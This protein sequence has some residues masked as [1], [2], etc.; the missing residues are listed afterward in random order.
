[1]CPKYGIFSEVSGIRLSHRP[2]QNIADGQWHHLAEVATTRNGTYTR[3]LYLDGKEVAKLDAA[4]ATPWWSLGD[5][6]IVKSKFIAS[7]GRVGKE[8]WKGQLDDFAVFDYA[9]TPDDVAYLYN[10]P[11]DADR[12][13]LKLVPVTKVEAGRNHTIQLPGSYKVQL[14][15]STPTIEGLKPRWRMVSGNGQVS[16]SDPDGASTVAM[17]EPV[18]DDKDG[19]YTKFV[20]R[21]SLVDHQGRELAGDN[22]TVL[23]HPA[24]APEI[25][26]LTE[27]PPP[28]EHPR[29][30]F[31]KADL[32][33]LRRRAEASP[34]A[35]RAVEMMR[36]RSKGLD[37]PDSV[38][39]AILADRD[40]SI[41][42]V[43]G[44]KGH[45]FFTP[46]MEAAY[47]NWLGEAG[48]TNTE[49]MQELARVF[50][51][52]CQES[53]TWYRPNYY[54]VLCHDV[55]W[56]VG[57]AYDL[58]HDYMDEAGRAE[59]RHLIS[60]MTSHR[61]SKGPYEPPQ[62]NATNHRG[63][64][65]H[66]FA[67]TLA[68]EG[69]EGFDEG[70]IDCIEKKD[71]IW[72]T[73]Y[74]IFESGLP[75]EGYAY[76][77]HGMSWMS[78]TILANTRRKN[79]ENLAET[80]RFYRAVSETP[81]RLLDKDGIRSHHDVVE[82]TETG[83]GLVPNPPNQ[84]M[85]A[86]YLWP[87]DRTIDYVWAQLSENLLKET[88][89]DRF[90]FLHAVFAEPVRYPD[91]TMTEAAGTLNT[92]HFC[93]DRGFMNA[94]NSWDEDSLRLNLRCRM[95][96]YYVGHVH[97]D[98][99]AF[100]LWGRNRMWF[101][102]RGKF[103][104]TI[105]EAQSGILIDGIGAHSANR[106][107]W[108]SFPGRF[109][110][111]KSDDVADIACGDAKPFYDWARSKPRAGEAVL[112]KDHGLKWS[113][114]YFPRNGERVPEW[115][116][117]TP[118]DLDGYG[119]AQG[120][121]KMNPVK[122]AF[123]TAALVKGEHPFVLIVDDFQKDDQEHEYTWFANVPW[124][125]S[126]EVVAEEEDSLI[127][128]HKEDA[129]GPFLLVKVLHAKGLKGIE[130]NRNPNLLGKEALLSERV[131][132][133]TGEVLAPDFRVLLYPYEQRDPQPKVS[134]RNGALT[135][136]IGDQ[137]RSLSTTKGTD[138]RTRLN[139]AN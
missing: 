86:K 107:S 65:D 122:R 60:R 21:L 109:L 116:E 133:S 62:G 46:V 7:R 128:K 82:D 93:P 57:I 10:G 30:F 63:S 98:C 94:R 78:M 104:G 138:G 38:Y 123:R 6:R 43:W 31:T 11:S 83:A 75:H 52:A 18:E 48:Q 99:N 135:I 4:I 100:E 80:T 47:V 53:L 33:E 136:T 77:N 22:T 132:I 59:A 25:R 111:F 42:P 110:E 5:N 71:A 124:K 66:I 70:V 9:V 27:T 95:D 120:L 24:R 56:P 134:G 3:K 85:I 23:F 67:T 87:E 16:F 40:F 49:K 112:V 106:N 28:G 36:T 129:G 125:G 137:V 44:S 90:G 58:L 115:M 121:Y 131:E 91:Q 13:N 92:A 89:E 73:Q 68:I 72:L 39:Q 108:P 45:G 34:V 69:E 15:G 114:F 113:D 2:P 64:H 79:R 8:S 19:K 32:P 105:Q 51:E 117:Y 61:Y 14:E 55:I 97:S 41:R 88:R 81:F 118:V 101:M 119:N 84:I 1:L 96:K 103:G 130:L 76:F 29:V 37:N 35:K 50:S 126:M 102:D 54:N 17:F 12:S 74:G 127:L 26:T 139:V 20:L